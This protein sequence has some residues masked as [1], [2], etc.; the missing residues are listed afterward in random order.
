MRQARPLLELIR[1]K[2]SRD[3]YDIVWGG[4]GAQHR[5]PRPLT[6]MTVGEVL[7]WQDS[8]DP[9][10]NSEAAG[11]Y[12]ILEDTLRGLVGQGVVFPGSPFD[13][14]TQDKLGVWLLRRRGLDAFLAGEITPEKFANSIAKEWASF[15][16]V[17]RVYNGK[18]MVNPGQSYYAGDGLN[19][20]GTTPQTVLSVL[21]YMRETQ[22]PPRWSFVDWIVGKLRKLFGLQS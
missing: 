12:Q 1:A 21:R 9:L 2:E 13:V 16:V 6:E 11:A 4:I 10:Y 7:A 8:I 15:P 19:K 17:T 14:F 18:R 3:D 22:T 5:P 20:A